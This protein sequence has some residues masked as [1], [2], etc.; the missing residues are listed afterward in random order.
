M[1]RQDYMTKREQR[2]LE[3]WEEGFNTAKKIYYAKGYRAKHAK[4]S[5]IIKELGAGI[6]GEKTGIAYK[7][8]NSTTPF[9]YP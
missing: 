1:N 3:F 9:T 8:E 2:D 7:T 4:L 6:L 5:K